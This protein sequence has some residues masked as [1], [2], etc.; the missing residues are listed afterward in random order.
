MTISEDDST[1]WCCDVRD[2]GKWQRAGSQKS[3]PWTPGSAGG[4]LE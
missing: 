1:E 2:P 3:L 4:R